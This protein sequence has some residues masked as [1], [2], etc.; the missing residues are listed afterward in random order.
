[1]S[2]GG[3][4]KP[5]TVHPPVGPALE[6]LFAEHNPGDRVRAERAI[7]YGTGTEIPEGTLGTVE[8][9][10]WNQTRGLS[11]VY[12][13]TGAREPTCNEYLIPMG[14]DGPREPRDRVPAVRIMRTEE[15]REFVASLPHDMAY[16]RGGRRIVIDSGELEQRL[17][18][19]VK[20]GIEDAD[21]VVRIT[22]K[23]REVLRI[24]E[25]GNVLEVR[26]GDK[27]GP[28]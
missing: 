4:G 8:V 9:R 2:A 27:G 12:W 6:R 20:R 14:A 25:G 21:P 26:R 24:H 17:L 22:P 7:I 15:I 18:A 1:M 10:R 19:F 11:L 5:E 13:D 23:G 16:V 28:S 3:K